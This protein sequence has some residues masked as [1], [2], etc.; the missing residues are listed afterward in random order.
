MKEILID[1]Y[2]LIFALGFNANH[3]SAQA[4]DRS[5]SR[6]IDYLVQRMEQAQRIKTTIVF[7]AKKLPVSESHIDSRKRDIRVLFAVGYEDA[8]SMVEELIAHHS[9]PK[10]LLVVSS[11][12]RIQTAASRRRASIVDS[13]RWLDQIESTTAPS[14]PNP[15]SDQSL[16]DKTTT[17]QWMEIFSD[18]DQDIAGDDLVTHSP[19]N[20]PESTTSAPS[21]GGETEADIEHDHFEQE[22]L[23]LDDELKDLLDDDLSID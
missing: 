6:L 1:G 9:H 17:Q 8:D 19:T 23:N 7:D 12:H 3:A 21:T 13:E 2:N 14:L 18:A 4:I 16:I 15:D 20:S 10:Q 5:R 11:D 22:M